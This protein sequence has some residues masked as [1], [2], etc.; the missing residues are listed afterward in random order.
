MSRKALG[1]VC[2][3]VVLAGCPP[4]VPVLRMIYNQG[5]F[6]DDAYVSILDGVDH[7]PSP[8]A[9]DG[10]VLTGASPEIRV[11]QWWGT[12][13]PA[14]TDE[15]DFVIRIFEDDGT[16]L[17]KMVPLY[18]IPV[19]AVAK[20]DTGENAK[21]EVGSWPIFEYSVEL[22]PFDLTPG[23]PYYLSIVNTTGHDWV[24]MWT[25][26]VGVDMEAYTRLS[27]EEDW[28]GTLTHDVAFRLWQ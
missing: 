6:G 18:S 24:W 15:D 16:G 1:L 9:A 8:Q 3:V 4:R 10:F 5:N 23:L 26:D 21:P 19:G 12:Q 7:T 27:D 22:I 14:I 11:I 2:I 20:T 28:T 25:D 17:P 13:D